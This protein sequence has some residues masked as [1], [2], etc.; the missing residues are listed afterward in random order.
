MDR[1][2]ALALFVAVAEHEG[3]AEAARRLNRSPAAVT[4]GVAAIEEHLQARLLNRTTRSVSLTDVGARYLEGS[5]RLLAAYDELEAIGQGERD[6]PRGI[7]NVTAPA[8]FGRLHVLPLVASFIERHAQVDVRLLL[9]DRVVSLVDEGLD[10]GVRLGPLP[11]LSLRAVKV[12]EVT[13]RVYASPFYL[14]RHEVPETPQ[15]LGN[16]GVIACTTVTPIADRWSFRIEG[17]MVPVAVKPRLVVNTTDAAL[18]A[19]VAG[20]GPTCIMSYQAQG[21]VAAG[22]L[23]PVLAEFE[24]P[25]SPIYLVHPAGR[26]LSLKVRRLLDHLAEGLRR[27]FGAADPAVVS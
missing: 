26:H 20:L 18:D 4:R 1:L 15:E 24:P 3:F 14:A 7:L 8:M 22:Q 12:G 2:D 13:R 25:P 10:L 27:K 23:V 9:L 21:P 16:H 5:R 6:E 17:A 19:A 11:D